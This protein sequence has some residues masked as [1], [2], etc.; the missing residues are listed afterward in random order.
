[1]GTGYVNRPRFGLCGG[2]SNEERLDA[3]LKA[4]TES[5]L[6]ADLLE[7]LTQGLSRQAFLRVMGNASSMPS[8]MKSKDNPYFALRAKA[9][10]RDSL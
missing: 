8:Y 4:A 6:T 3:V 2:I 10:S 9:P 1:M 5:G 7:V